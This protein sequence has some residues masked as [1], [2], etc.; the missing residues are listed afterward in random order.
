M[1]KH[2]IS[3]IIPIEP[4]GTKLARAHAVTALF[5]AGNIVLP[6]SSLCPWVDD[7]RLELTRFPNGAHD[8]QVDAAAAMTLLSSAW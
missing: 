7:F 8:D 5:E 6:D 4:D 2:E 3:G 1:L